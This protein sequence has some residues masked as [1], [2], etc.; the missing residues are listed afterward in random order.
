M[1][2]RDFT[3]VT[4]HGTEQFEVAAGRVD[5]LHFSL[6]GEGNGSPEDVS[7]HL[8]YHLWVAGDGEYIFLRAERRR[9]PGDWRDAPV[10]RARGRRLSARPWVRP[11]RPA[12]RA[13]AGAR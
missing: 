7:H 13:A 12:P 10:P 9:D 8:P 3:V 11:C 4:F 5:A 1:L 6:G 2:C